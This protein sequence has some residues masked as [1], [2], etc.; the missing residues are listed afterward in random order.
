MAH[1]ESLSSFRPGFESRS[2][3][4]IQVRNG[5]ELASPMPFSTFS[6][7]DFSAIDS[8][9]AELG[10]NH[11]GECEL[12]SILIIMFC[13]L[14]DIEKKR[15]YCRLHKVKLGFYATFPRPK[16]IV[17]IPAAATKTSPTTMFIIL[18]PEVN[19]AAIPIMNNAPP[20]I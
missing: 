14:M 11:Q 8:E 6:P 18:P 7:I 17:A 1:H 10:A 16:A 15:L 5:E 20:A 4:L 19:I 3:R 13:G 2:G 12:E 9:N